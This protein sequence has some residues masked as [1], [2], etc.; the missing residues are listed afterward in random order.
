MAG[1]CQE[2][3]IAHPHTL[4]NIHYVFFSVLYV[5][6][7]YLMYLESVPTLEQSVSWALIGGL[8]Y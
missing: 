4:K 1:Y 2:I 3:E 6:S 7:T 5:S 8:D